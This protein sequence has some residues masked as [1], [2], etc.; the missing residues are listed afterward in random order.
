MQPLDHQQGNQGCP[1]LDA[2][3]VLALS[4]EGFDLQVL[5][6]RLEEELDLPPVPVDL[7]YGARPEPKMI[8]EKNDIL[9]CFRRRSLSVF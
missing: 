4:Y 8:G 7:T 9:S 5:L 3:G 2:K 6:Q 1:N